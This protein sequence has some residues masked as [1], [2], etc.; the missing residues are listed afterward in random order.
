M[1][2]ITT[3]PD[4][5]SILRVLLA[6]LVVLMPYAK[7]IPMPTIAAILFMVAYNMCGWREF[8]AIIKNSPKGDVLV[9]VV[10]FLLTV[11]FDLV[12]AIVAGLILA[13]GLKWIGSAVKK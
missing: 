13:Y 3:L 12:V 11:V 5:S 4:L 2:N 7:L 10:T 1:A 6:M 9:L 8:S